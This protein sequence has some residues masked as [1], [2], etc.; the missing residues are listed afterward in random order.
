V[1]HFEKLYFYFLS[2]VGK[3]AFY[4]RSFE[5][6]STISMFCL[7]DKRN[8]IGKMT[9]LL[10]NNRA[11]KTPALCISGVTRFSARVRGVCPPPPSFY[12]AIYKLMLV[13]PK[14]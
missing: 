7:K 2:T 5:P 6:T 3:I 9:G 8:K 10:K 13:K 11:R 14:I 1:E 4:D 12:P